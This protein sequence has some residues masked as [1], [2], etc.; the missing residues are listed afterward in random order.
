MSATS[1]N[2]HSS[3]SHTI[4]RISVETSP[5]PG[6]CD[7]GGARTLAVLNMIDL[8]GSE[9]AKVGVLVRVLE[10]TFACTGSELDHHAC[11]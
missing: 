10:V 3:R 7:I 11:K 5:A 9:S 8:A 4:I 2:D 6:T 1:Y